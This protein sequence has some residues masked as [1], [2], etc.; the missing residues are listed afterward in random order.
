MA[1]VFSP[2]AFRGGRS[3]LPRKQARL[4]WDLQPLLFLLYLFD[5]DQRSQIIYEF[6]IIQS[7]K[8]KTQ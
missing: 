4:L 5:F 3:Q 7:N 8:N 1:C 2:V 6:I